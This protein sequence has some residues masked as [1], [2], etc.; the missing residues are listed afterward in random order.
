MIFVFQEKFCNII[1]NN[2][3]AR[4]QNVELYDI[5]FQMGF[6][7]DNKNKGKLL[8]EFLF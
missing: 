7:A 4:W 2:N 3:T 6:Y 1:N 5:Q 8:E